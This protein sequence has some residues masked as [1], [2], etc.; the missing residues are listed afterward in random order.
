MRCALLVLMLALGGCGVP[1]NPPLVSAQTPPAVGAV[2]SAG[3]PQPINSLPPGAAGRPWT[4]NSVHPDYLSATF[5]R[6]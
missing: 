3:M 1:A 4:V 2:G 6:R 5:G